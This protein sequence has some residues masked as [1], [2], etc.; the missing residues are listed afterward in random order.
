MFALTCVS[1][2][3]VRLPLDD[4]IKD[5]APIAKAS[6]PSPPRVA[7]QNPQPQQVDMATFGACQPPP[8]QV[9]FQ[10]PPPP[11]PPQFALGPQGFGAF[12]FAPPFQPV[13]F[14]AF[15]AAQ[16]GAHGFAGLQQVGGQCIGVGQAFGWPKCA[17]FVPMVFP[18]GGVGPPPAGVGPPP[19]ARPQEEPPNRQLTRQDSTGRM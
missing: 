2:C 5:G 8:P 19:P 15:Q 7:F 10:M 18:C 12:P 3:F 6:P 13:A 1:D 11:R 14:P 17:N 4:S 16:C 9:A